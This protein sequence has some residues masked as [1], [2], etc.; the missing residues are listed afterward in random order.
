[1]KIPLKLAPGV[2]SD[3]TDFNT[4]GWISADNVRFWRGQ[5][6]TIK[7]FEAFSLTALT[8]VCRSIFPWSDGDNLLN[9]AFGLHNGLT[10]WQA[11]TQAS[12]TPASVA[13]TGTI[14]VSGTPVANETLVVGAQTFTFKVARSIAG[15]VTISATPSTQAANIAAAITA[16]IASTATAAAVS[17]VVTVTAATAGVVG[18][19]IVLTEAAT[20]IAVS[21]SG[22]LSGGSGFVAGQIDGTGGAGYGTGAYGVGDYGEPSTTDYYPMTWSF[23][24]RS[25]GELYANPRGQGVFVW[26]NNPAAS[27]TALSNAPPVVNSIAVAWTDQVI[28]FGCTDVGGSFNASCI[29]ISDATDPTIWTPLPSNTAQQYYLKG[30]GRIVRALPVGR[31]LFVWTDSELHIGSFNGSWDFEPLGA[32]GLAGQGAAVIIGQTAY[33][34]APDLQFYTCPLGGAPGLIQPPCPIRDD[35]ADNAAIGQNDKIVASSLTERGEISWFYSDARDGTGYENSRAIRLSVSDGAWAPDTLARTA[36]VDA[37]PAPTPIGVT[38]A[39]QIYWHERGSSSDGS[40][41]AASLKT[42]GQYMDPAERVMMLR[43][44]WPDFRDQVGAINLTIYSRF[45]PQDTPVSNGPFLCAPD[46]NKV[47]FLVTGR[48]FDFEFTSD[49]SPMAWR[50]GKPVFDAAVIGER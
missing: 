8:G 35:F 20:G 32:G 9:A 14:T 45:Y 37:N 28:A 30:N 3:D 10:V 19:L 31:Y 6:E 42:G 13:A 5:P 41:L 47:D 15:E 50:M 16:D 23:G 39:G 48:I 44:M 33:W 7:G 11:G 40:A 27:A 36:F 17:A 38:L 18:N 4:G 25:F 22:K 34:I 26:N 12:I 49:S 1:M 43:G 2:V 21:G 46:A 24:V 29:R